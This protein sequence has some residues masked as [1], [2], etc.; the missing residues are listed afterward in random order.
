MSGSQKHPDNAVTVGHTSDN[1]YFR[2]TAQQH[3]AEDTTSWKMCSR[4]HP[5]SSKDHSYSHMLTNMWPMCN[6][7]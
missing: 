4:K 1:F 3:L 6:L 2:G 7:L 5:T